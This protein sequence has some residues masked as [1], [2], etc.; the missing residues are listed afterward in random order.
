[1]SE[2]T[3]SLAITTIQNDLKKKVTFAEMSDAEKRT[4]IDQLFPLGVAFWYDD[5]K[6]SVGDKIFGWGEP[7]LNTGGFFFGELASLPT[8]GVWAES[9][10][11]FKI[12]Y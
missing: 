8:G 6:A 9:N 3:N 12:K 4:V 7:T 10:I 5:P 1:M 11:N 2:V